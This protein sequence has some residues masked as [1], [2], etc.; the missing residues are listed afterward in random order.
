L[1]LPILGSTIE[2]SKIPEGVYKIMSDTDSLQTAANIATIYQV[3]APIVIGGVAGAFGGLA[4]A[5]FFL[6]KERRLVSNWKRPIAIIPS[7]EH[8]MNNEHTLLK[9]SAFF[10]NVELM[11]PQ[12]TSVNLITN[13]YRLVILRYEKESSYFWDVYEDLVSRQIPIIIYAEQ[14]SIDGKDF[15]RLQKYLLHTICNTPVR[16]LSDVAA[17][18]GTYPSAKELE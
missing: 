4:Y 6:K 2:P 18:M 14:G 3:V 17:L 8:P 11:A 9:K 13:K 7:N 1:K 5:L 10:D 16:L 15:P 12:G